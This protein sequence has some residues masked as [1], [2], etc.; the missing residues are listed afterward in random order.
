MDPITDSMTGHKPKVSAKFK[1]DPNTEK[2]SVSWIC[3]GGGG[4]FRYTFFRFYIRLRRKV[5]GKWKYTDTLIGGMSGPG[6][7]DIWKPKTKNWDNAKT[8]TKTVKKGANTQCCF[9]V[10]C[11]AQ[12]DGGSCDSDW[13]GGVTRITDYYKLD[14]ETPKPTLS[15]AEDYQYTDPIT[16][17]LDENQS[18]W[19]NRL[20]VHWSITGTEKATRLACSLTRVSDKVVVDTPYPVSSPLKLDD[21][22]SG[23]ITFSNIEKA[24]SWYLC[25]LAVAGDDEKISDKWE[26]DFRSKRFRTRDWDPYVYFENGTM[27]GTSLSFT[28]RSI[29]I[30]TNGV[31]KLATL[32]YQVRDDDTGTIKTGYIIKDREASEGTT[33]TYKGSYTITGLTEGHTYTVTPIADTYSLVN[34]VPMA[35]GYGVTVQGA[36][37]PILGKIYNMSDGTLVFG[38]PDGSPNIKVDITGTANAWAITMKIGTTIANNVVSNPITTVNATIGTNT[39]KLTDAMLD[40]LYKTMSTN[41]NTRVYVSIEYS[42]ASS[43][44][45]SG[46]QYGSKVMTLKGN[47]KTSKVGVA[48]KPRRA[49][50]WVGVAGKPRRAVFWGGVAGKP[51][52]TL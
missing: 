46:K 43:G 37:P 14:A 22:K 5:D 28:Y 19:M 17:E 47:A 27:S 18:K 7:E 30:T 15:L 42:L 29:S 40:T 52:R 50:A 51:R 44:G 36:T 8:V 3:N 11:S 13:G 10:Y 39:V 34:H 32:R 45:S 2:A 26:D 48:G 4:Y 25:T 24:G 31:C 1:Y 35:A 33:D 23:D 21:K 16:G 9:C 49:K 12:K 6:G 41:S 20:K 38:E